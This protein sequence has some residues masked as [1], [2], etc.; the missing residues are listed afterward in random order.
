MIENVSYKRTGNYLQQIKGSV[1][2]KL[3][4]IFAS[5]LAS[6]NNGTSTLTAPDA[7]ALR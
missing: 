4:V 5:F 7:A 6:P 3:G 1:F 2:Y